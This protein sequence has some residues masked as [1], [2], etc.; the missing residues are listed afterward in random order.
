MATAQT[1]PIN[2]LLILSVR[3]KRL[4]R[5]ERITYRLPILSVRLKLLRGSGRGERRYPSRMK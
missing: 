1:S 5:N 3:L 4:P 2:H